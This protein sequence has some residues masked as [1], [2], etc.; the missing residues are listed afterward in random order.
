MLRIEASDCEGA[1]LRQSLTF[2]IW[3]SGLTV[4]LMLDKRGKSALSLRLFGVD[5]SASA[6]QV[7]DNV[8]AEGEDAQAD[9]VEP[10]VEE[11]TSN[12]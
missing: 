11:P 6:K 1:A 12:D 2:P 5:L 9:E 7:T 10:D 4:S 8:Q 3:K